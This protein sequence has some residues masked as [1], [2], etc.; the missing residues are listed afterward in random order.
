[1]ADLK[2]RSEASPNSKTLAIKVEDF[3]YQ[4]MEQ[5]NGRASMIRFEL[6]NPDIKAGDVLVVLAGS[7]IQFHGLIM[8]VEDGWATTTDYHS[9]LISDTVH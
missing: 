1:M 7:E 2:A 8:R 9:L 4:T 6:K 3:S 5:V